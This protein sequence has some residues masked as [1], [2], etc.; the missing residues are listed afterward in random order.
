MVAAIET[1]DS[2]N[3]ILDYNENTVK[4]R[5]SECIA[6]VNYPGSWKLSFNKKLNSLVNQAD[7]NEN[8]TSKSV[9]SLWSLSR[10][11]SNFPGT[12]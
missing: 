10:Q 6:A 4:E 1:A 11:S 3:R 2:I 12:N 9:T 5:V 7:L 8:V